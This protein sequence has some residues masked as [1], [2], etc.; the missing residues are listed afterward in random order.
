MLI[1]LLGEV[2]PGDPPVEL[3]RKITRFQPLPAIRA[4]V[5]RQL[6]WI[7]RSGALTDFPALVNQLVGDSDSSVTIAAVTALAGLPESA[8]TVVEEALRVALGDRDKEVQMA[9]LRTVAATGLAGLAAGSHL[10]QVSDAGN[11]RAKVE[12]AKLIPKI[13]KVLESKV[14]TDLVKSLFADDADEVRRA[15]VEAFPKIIEQFGEEWR[16]TVLLPIIKGLAGSVD[17]QLRKSAVSAA[18][19]LGVDNADCE[20]V[21][22]NAVKDPVQNVRIVIAKE[23]PRGSQLLEL[24]KGDSDPDVAFYA[25]KS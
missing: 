3:I 14:L 7:Y 16:G 22:R 13:A 15:T 18:I 19:I 21:V 20:N 11:W 8:A 6:P 24:L 9:A 12:V 2:F 1:E 5:A 4:A 10:A 23:L 25:S 17:Y